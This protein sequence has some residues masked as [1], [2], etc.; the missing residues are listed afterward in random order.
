M[1]LL[2]RLWVVILWIIFLCYLS[3][4]VLPLTVFLAKGTIYFD[5]FSDYIEDLTY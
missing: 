5:E 4:L 1:T 3:S 2:R